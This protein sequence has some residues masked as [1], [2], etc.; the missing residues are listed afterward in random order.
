M[1]SAWVIVAPTAAS[2]PR[3][4][5][6]G[7]SQAEQLQPRRG[8]LGQP[9]R[10]STLCA[11]LAPVIPTLICALCLVVNDFFMYALNRGSPAVNRIRRLS[12]R[13][14]IYYENARDSKTLWYFLPTRTYTGSDFRFEIPVTSRHHWPPSSR[15]QQLT[16]LPFGVQPDSSFFTHTAKG[17]RIYNSWRTQ[18][19]F[20]LNFEF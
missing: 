13:P 7:F 17:T 9:Y 3:R 12:Q 4:L 15:T 8:K 20:V 14:S 19:T 5:T 2:R 6:Y 16:P 11:P 1:V 10:E 18:G